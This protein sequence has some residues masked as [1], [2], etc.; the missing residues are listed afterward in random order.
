MSKTQ[1]FIIAIGLFL[2]MPTWSFFAGLISFP[3]SLYVGVGFLGLVGVVV[4]V[5]WTFFEIVGLLYHK[6][7][8]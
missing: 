4:F 1:W 6:F 3:S 2:V 8:N 7:S 5:G